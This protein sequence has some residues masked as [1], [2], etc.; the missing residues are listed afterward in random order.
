MCSHN[1]RRIAA[2]LLV[3]AAV[4]LACA[5]PSRALS[6]VQPRRGI[7]EDSARELPGRGFVTFLLE[8]FGFAGGAMDPNGAH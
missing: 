2:T 7:T 6:W 1:S 5:A 8:L 4:T 3:A